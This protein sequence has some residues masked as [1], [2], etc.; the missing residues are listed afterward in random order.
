MDLSKV[1]GTINYGLLLA[2]LKVY[3]ISENVLKLLCSCYLKDWRRA[4]QT[5]NNFSPYEKVQAG[6]PQ[7]TIAGPLV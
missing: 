4:V 7:E 5:N 6:V 2:Q 3:E 1:F